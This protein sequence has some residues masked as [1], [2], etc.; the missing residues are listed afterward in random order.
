MRQRGPSFPVKSSER[1]EPRHGWRNSEG[2][3]GNSRISAVGAEENG[4]DDLCKWCSGAGKITIPERNGGNR[5]GR[6]RRWVESRKYWGRKTTM[7]NT[8][9]QS[10]GPPMEAPNFFWRRAKSPDNSPTAV[11]TSRETWERKKLTLMAVASSCR[12]GIV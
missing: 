9:E 8:E 2:C 11:N 6:A 7:E 10:P 12:P 5:E 1:A 3:P 4:E